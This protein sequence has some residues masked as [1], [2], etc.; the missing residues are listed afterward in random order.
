MSNVR[1]KE[2]YDAVTGDTTD[3]KYYGIDAAVFRKVDN[4]RMLFDS[5]GEY[6][7]IITCKGSLV[8]GKYTT[9]KGPYDFKSF[10]D[11]KIWAGKGCNLSNFIETKDGDFLQIDGPKRQ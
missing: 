9:K 5:R 11:L 4:V 3:G 6:L 1:K 7:G 10:S 2:F 8:N